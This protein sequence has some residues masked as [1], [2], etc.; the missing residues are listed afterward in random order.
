M[1]KKNDLDAPVAFAPVDFTPAAS[2][3]REAFDLAALAVAI[4]TRHPRR[5]PAPVSGR[6]ADGDVQLNLTVSPSLRRRLKETARAH[7]VTMAEL[8]EAVLDQALPPE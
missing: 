2:S 8:L 4:H 5:P 7:G 3:S 1:P 6:R